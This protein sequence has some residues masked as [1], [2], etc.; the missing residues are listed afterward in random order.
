M[1]EQEQTT[2]AET[3]EEKEGRK[4]NLPPREEA[5]LVTETPNTQGGFYIGQARV[6][7]TRIK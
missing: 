4:V 1:N 3:S 7:R 6:G 2:K 5:S